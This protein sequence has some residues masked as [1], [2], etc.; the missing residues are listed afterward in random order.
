MATKNLVVFAEIIHYSNSPSKLDNA[1]NWLDSYINHSAFWSNPVEEEIQILKDKLIH[2]IPALKN[3]EVGPEYA[4]K[5]FLHAACYELAIQYTY[6][7]LSHY[8]KV[9]EWGLNHSGAVFSH[10][11]TQFLKEDIPEYVIW[12][13]RDFE[14]LMAK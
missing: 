8:I 6:T 10:S 7:N 13:F 1:E 2:V 14:N 12:Y 5:L 9:L 3:G 4:E 11:K